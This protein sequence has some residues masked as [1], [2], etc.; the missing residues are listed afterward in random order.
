MHRFRFTVLTLGLLAAFDQSAFA[1]RLRP[2]RAASYVKPAPLQDD[3]ALHDVKFVGTS[4]GWAVGD[5]GVIW[6]TTDGGRSWGLLPSPVDCPLRG[7]CFLTDRIGWIVGGGTAPYTRIGYGVVL[8]TRDGGATWQVLAGKRF[9]RKTKMSTK[10]PVTKTYY[11][12]TSTRPSRP[13]GPGHSSIPSKPVG[14]VSNDQRRNI[15]RGLRGDQSQ[16]L[17]TGRGNTKPTASFPLPSLF[18]VKFFGLKRGIVVGEASSRVPSG[19]L[20]TTDGGQSWKPLPGT[21]RPGW[22]AADF[23]SPQVGFVA[24]MHGHSALVG[25]GRLLK[26]A[27]D[28]T[29]LRAL[30]GVS[31]KSDDTGWLVGDGGLV[32]RTDNGGVIWRDP[33]K[34]LPKE[35]RDVANFRAVHSRKRKVWL[36]GSPGSVIW[37][38]ADG[39][40]SWVQQQTG[41]TVPIHAITFTTDRVGWAV[42]AMGTMLVTQNGGRSW[43]IARGGRRR[44]A[45]LSIHGRQRDL[46]FPL[47]V[48]LAADQGYRTAVLQAARSDFSPDG[49]TGISRGPQLSEA[50][51]AAGGSAAVI[52]W[53][54]PIAVPGL[55][56]NDERLWDDWNHRTEGRLRTVLLSSLVA[57]IRT[58]RP[59]VVVLDHAAKDD[60]LT[61]LVNQAALR[62]IR[63]A[64][65]PTE[66]VKQSA[67]TGLRPWK[68]TKV[69]VRLTDGS[70]GDAY[71][72]PH[73]HLYYLGET[74]HVAAAKAE[75][76]LRPPTRPSAKRQAYRLLL[77]NTSNGE[78]KAAHR[79][80]FKG[81]NI[82]PGTEARRQLGTINDA[83]AEQLMALAKR[84]RNFQAIAAAT[85]DKSRAAAQMIAQL[86]KITEG[87]PAER[88]A[89]Q[90]LQLADDYRRRSQ[91]ELAE[92]TW[93][94]T[95]S[96]YP[97]ANASL[98]AMQRL[99]QLW[100]GA[101]PVWHRVS[102]IGVSRSR[103]VADTTQLQKRLER[104][105]I[106]AKIPANQRDARMFDLGP[107]PAKFRTEPDGHALNRNMERRQKGV[108]HWQNQALRM[109]ALIRKRDPELYLSP[110]VQFPLA[111]LLRSRGIPA[112]ARQ[113]YL[114]F[115]KARGNDVWK[116]VADSEMWMLA[117]NGRPPRQTALCV[118]A[119]R[120]PKLDGVLSDGCWQTA[121]VLRLTNA[122]ESHR[123]LQSEAFVMLCYDAEY[124]YVS[125][126]VPMAVTPRGFDAETG[127]RKRDADLSKFDNIAFHFDTDRDYAT[128]FTLKVDQRGWTADACWGDATWNPKW[129]VAHDKDEKTWR[130]EAA[131]P[132]KELG[133]TRPR[134]GGVWSIGV[135]RTVPAIG[136]Q[137]WTHPI[138]K[139]PRAETF[140]LLRFD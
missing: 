67:A 104:A 90:L 96:R 103:M 46:S 47:L 101:E 43:H 87:M 45:L 50:I 28:N 86:G 122:K 49:P 16:Q 14:S 33:P 68:V 34:K 135:V 53:R 105:A 88:A 92:A 107:D 116:S 8:H 98:E 94:E 59:S 7:V 75:T 126:S 37:H 91:W 62:A 140:G 9:V 55:D 22:R 74:N 5:H 65:D 27:V 64:A 30:R 69:Y 81:L 19:V 93:I 12:G 70:A 60:A 125:G 102:K 111:A 83:N 76:K 113:S 133:P 11:G 131:I 40:K 78:R 18:Y 85:L 117:P 52:D 41:Q 66:F 6:R 31:L 127:K 124:L 120:R 72:S 106:L 13:I 23:V 95:V 77:D 84:Q 137:S 57:R 24:G 138:R 51:A 21:R 56:K 15:S 136:V 39:G 97:N 61:R 79:D 129:F 132:L 114:T 58:W 109:A 3:A 115:Q 48:K 112:A 1:Q 130:F 17:N 38:S 110:R 44:A 71:V 118:L 119:D 29:G 73:T 63:Q 32:L 99:F 121:K 100:V 25:G 89:A 10:A 4:H 26:P 35:L 108:A 20:F 139:T 128:Y 42:G 134:R 2:D 36:S 123:K 82:W 80:F 54:F